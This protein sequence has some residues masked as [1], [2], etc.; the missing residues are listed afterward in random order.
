MASVTYIVGVSS[1]NKPCPNCYIQRTFPCTGCKN[2]QEMERDYE[3]KTMEVTSEEMDRA[4]PHVSFETLCPGDR[5]V[6]VHMEE[7]RSVPCANCYEYFFPCGNKHDGGSCKVS[8]DGIRPHGR[9]FPETLSD[10]L[11][12][13]RKGKNKMMD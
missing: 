7:Q 10:Y 5:V 1:D 6:G 8:Y 9:C 11:S 13:T 12:L 3:A 2:R 4:Y